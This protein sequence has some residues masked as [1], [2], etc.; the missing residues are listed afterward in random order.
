MADR[1]GAAGA[2]IV[3][4]A[5]RENRLQEAV[6]DLKSKGVEATY[7]VADVTNE[8]SIQ[9]LANFVFGTYGKV[10]VLVN[11]AGITGAPGMVVDQSKEAYQNVL[12]VNV[13]GMLNGVWA[14]G[15]RMIEQGTKAMII[16]VGSEVGLYPI[17][18]T[19]STYSAS[20]YMQRA[21][22]IA[23]SMEM[24]EQIEVCGVYPGLVQ[25]EL[26]G[27]KAQ[28]Q[29]GMKAS[30]YMDIIWPQIENGELY[31]VSHPWGKD[32]F[33]Q[34]AGAVISSFEKYAPHYEGDEEF[35]TISIARKM[36]AN[37]QQ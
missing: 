6:E 22:T 21:L 24:P 30:D 20:K 33:Q 5:R 37:Q 35:D 26:G 11:N 2:K 12:D 15:K 32:Y 1:F 18:P 34:S 19:M 10:D 7:K 17:G 31:V 3:L 16:N 27:S 13:F 28:T 29:A 4:S 23:L 36:F 25:S 14:F 9:S 8:D